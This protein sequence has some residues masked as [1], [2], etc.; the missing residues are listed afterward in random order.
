MPFAT[1]QMDLEVIKLSEVSQR[2]NKHDIA[3]IWNLKYDTNQPI[4]KTKTNSQIWRTD[5]WL[6][7][8]QDGLAVWD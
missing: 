4:Y 3:Y 8:R 5:L 1:T 6:S 2:K 7:R